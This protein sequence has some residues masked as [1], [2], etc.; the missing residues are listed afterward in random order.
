[1]KTGP[2]IRAPLSQAEAEDPNYLAQ[3]M[4]PLPL[5]LFAATDVHEL[6]TLLMVGLGIRKGRRL[7][8]INGTHTQND[9]LGHNTL[10]STINRDHTKMTY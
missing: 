6:K 1:M 8:T 3:G 4:K 10:G 2:C 7:S 5:N 9:L